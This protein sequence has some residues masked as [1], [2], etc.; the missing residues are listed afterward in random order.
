MAAVANGLALHGGLRPYVATFF[1]FSDYLRPAMRLAA[2]MGLPVDLRVHARQHRR[3]RGRADAPAGRAPRRAARDPRT[4]RP[5]PGRRQ[6]D[7]G[8]LAGRAVARTDEPVALMLTRQRVPTID[9]DKYGPAV[10]VARGALRA[11]GRAG[12]RRG[13]SRRRPLRRPRHHPHRQRQRGPARARRARAAGRRRRALARRQPRQLAPLR[14]SG[15]RLPR[16]RSFRPPAAAGWRSRRPPRSAGSA[17]SAS[18]ARPS[19]STVSARRLRGTSSSRSS[20]SPPT[21]CTHGPGPFSTKESTD[22]EHPG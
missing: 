15:R 20:A 22:D 1:V 18:T 13:R 8:G 16:E 10:G 9:R 5:A 7:G 11:R 3:R 2:L 6:R 4:D 19:P 14:G 12:G 17:G 21:T